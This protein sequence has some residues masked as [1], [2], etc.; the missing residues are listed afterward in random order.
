RPAVE[1]GENLGFLPGDLAEKINPYLRPLFDA[2]ADTIQPEMARQFATDGRIEVAPL[3]Y[4]RGRTLNDAYVILDEAQNTTVS[5]MKMFLTRMGQNSRFVVCGDA[6]QSDL[7]RRVKNGLADA[8]ERLRDIDEIAW[9]TLGK[10]D[11]VRHVLVQKIV[12]AY[13]RDF[14]DD[15]YS[16]AP[17]RSPRFD[18]NDRNNA[19]EG[20]SGAVR[21]SLFTPERG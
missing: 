5:Q 9:M 20:A 11:V 15:R 10:S 17:E 19:A 12:E 16:G 4:M 18:Q 2:L 13:E 14:D 1:A 21:S 8:F 3:A 7:G 6:A